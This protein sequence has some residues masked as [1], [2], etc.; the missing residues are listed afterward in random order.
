MYLSICI[1][2]YIIDMYS[3][4]IY[5]IMISQPGPRMRGSLG[6]P[7]RMRGSLDIYIY[8]YIYFIYYNEPKV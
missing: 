5:N 7:A 8:I 4:Y 2:I 1:Y 6:Y 3:V